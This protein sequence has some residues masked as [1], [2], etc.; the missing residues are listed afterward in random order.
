MQV[1]KSAYQWWW[2]GVACRAPRIHLNEKT[3]KR[4]ISQTTPPDPASIIIIIG[5]PDITGPHWG[6]LNTDAGSW[7]WAKTMTIKPSQTH[8]RGKMYLRKH[9]CYRQYACT[10]QDRGIYKLFYLLDASAFER[11]SPYSCLNGA[12][13][14]PPTDIRHHVLYQVMTHL[15]IWHLTVSKTRD[16]W[17]T[18]SHVNSQ[19]EL[20]IWIICLPAT[21]KR[22]FRHLNWH[23]HVPIVCSR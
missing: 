1:S 4:E 9:I 12:V 21:T 8:N 3:S 5:E 14:S 13:I 19:N 17:T 23:L 22:L 11:Q 2:D 6:C 7:P 20:M 18:N 15:M 10:S 16:M